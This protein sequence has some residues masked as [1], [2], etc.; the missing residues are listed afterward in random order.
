MNYTVELGKRYVQSLMGRAF[1]PTVLSV[2]I[3][4]VCDM[5]CVH[6]FFTEELDDKPRKAK[7]MKTDNLVR[8]S[9]TLGGNLPA[10][11]VAGGEPFTRKDLPEVANAFYRNNNLDSI[12][13]MSNGQIQKRILPDVERILNECPQMNV[14]VALGID[15]LQEDHEKIRQK[16]GSWSIAVD[17]ARQLQQLKKR[18]PRLDIQ[19]CTCFMNS[20]QDRIFEWYEFLKYD[21]KP[22]KI[23]VNYIR[24]PSARSEELNI[25]ISRYR[26][27]AHTIDTDTRSAAIKNSYSGNSGLFRAAVD[28]YMHELIA[29]TEMEQKA[30]LRCWAGTAGAVIYDEGTISSCENLESVGNLRDYDW[31][32]Q[33]FWQ[34]EAMQ[35]R[36]E[37][38]KDGCFCTHESNCYYPSLPFNPKHLIQIKRLEK[39][40]RNAQ[41]KDIRLTPQP[42]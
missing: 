21:L 11:I 29:R 38:V 28:V 40:M 20:N 30:Q 17:T 13:L 8:I 4:S 31:D 41:K 9:E 19:T 12:Y 27:L 15:G 1:A 24:P 32:F 6:C 10:L 33:S 25:D 18:F 26:Q 39:Q 7:Q 2:L 16:P 22:D 42:A 37:K 23:N 34:S 35:K 5:R 3:T 14:T 36:R